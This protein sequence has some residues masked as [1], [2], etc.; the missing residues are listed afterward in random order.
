MNGEYLLSQTPGAER[1]RELF[2]RNFR[3]YPRGVN[4]FDVYSP[5]ISTLYSQVYWKGFPPVDLPADV[6]ER[7]KG[8]KVMAVV[9]FEL[10]Q[11]RRTAGGDVSVPINMAYN[12]HFESHM[13][14]AGSRLEKIVF[15]GPNDPRRL[16]YEAHGHGHGV[17]DEIWIA[18]EVTP[19]ANGFPTSQ[20][21]GAG[22]GGESRKTFHGYPPGYSQVIESP[23]QFQITP[24]Q[25]DT[26]HREKM[27]LTGSP[28]VSGPLP[29]SSL[30]PADAIYS[31]LLECPVT[32]RLRKD[33]EGD[34]EA[35]G[36]GRCKD[37]IQSASECYAAAAKEF[38]AGSGSW[39]QVN[40]T[41]D[42]PAKP[43]GCSANLQPTT[44]KVD[45]TFNKAG[46]A[47]AA[48]CGAR[49]S[50]LIGVTTSLVTL[51]V[52]LD[53]KKQEVVIRIA[54]PDNVWFG[55]GFNASAMEDSPWAIIV[56]GR[57]GVSERK[58][59]DQ[60]PGTELAKSVT[61]VSSEVS[62]GHR[63]VVLTRPMKGQ[64]PDYYS[65]GSDQEVILPFI[66]AVGNSPEL[67]Y[68]KIKAPSSIALLPVA[69]ADSAGACVCPTKPA[70]F[71]DAKGSLRYVPTSQQG[72]SGQ[73]TTINFNNKCA[74]PPRGSLYAQR[75]PTCDVRT[76]SGGQLACHHMF[77][78]L[79]ADQDIPWPNR[80][81]NYSLKFRFWYQDFNESYHTIVG[82]QG[83]GGSGWDLGAGP[84]G[85]GAE[86]DV[87]KCA[88]GVAGCSQAKDGTWVHT[89]T[90]TFVAKGR[91]VAAH[92]HCHAP[93][94]L[95]MAIYNNHTGDL[96]CEEKPVYGG[97][98]KIDNKQMD[99]PGFILV[100]PCLWGSP[101]HGLAPPPKLDGLTVT[102]V[103]KSNA[104]YGHHGEMAHGQV[105]F[106]VKD[107]EVPSDH[108]YI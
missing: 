15:D 48:E 23:E 20:S 22:N 79:D 26:W 43:A 25:I 87:P 101:E 50:G 81:L 106:V 84:S 41:V 86:F 14:G 1:T 63:T 89:I 59:A 78:L 100:P 7:Y 99:E 62:S 96:I 69:G 91:P 51:N 42:D 33:V 85:V 66:N 6:V 71:G 2:P 39:Q 83:Q 108:F 29:Q 94:C 8:G 52:S 92:M 27:N 54:G 46:A 95:S 93:T 18:R 97:T 80:P 13:A 105:F 65:F 74:L 19:S 53:F 5:T 61:V 11:V 107:P 40:L 24:M 17:N 21:F 36:S 90:G 64:T 55:V 28:F 45:V 102:V 98:G 47:D 57:G 82:T 58:L 49:A 44:G 31:G 75:N 37:L 56:D 76:Y 16:K 77:S 10:D 30:A 68:H 103:K 60:S 12:H 4:Y 72:E 70:P 88:P 104:T 32:T 3:D 67:A 38:G 34:Y 9:G 35:L 73:A